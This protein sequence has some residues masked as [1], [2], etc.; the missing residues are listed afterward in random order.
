MVKLDNQSFETC[1][2][3]KSNANSFSW[4]KNS[5]LN[6]HSSISDKSGLDIQSKSLQSLNV[7]S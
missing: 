2:L 4:D 5:N 6:D 3:Y 7:Q 1:F